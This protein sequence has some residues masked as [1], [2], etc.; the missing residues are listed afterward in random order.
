MPATTEMPGPIPTAPCCSFDP[1]LPED[2]QGCA[3]GLTERA[4]RAG[5]KLT[6]E[7]RAWCIDEI[8][9]VEGHTRDEC[10]G[11]DDAELGRA[12]LGAWVD[13][14]RDKGLL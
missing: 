4:L 10:E 1:A 2:Q 11:L 9:S 3:C 12:V 14:C 6:A 5:A 8:A 7:Q 13:Y